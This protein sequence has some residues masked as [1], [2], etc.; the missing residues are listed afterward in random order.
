MKI[1]SSLGDPFAAVVVAL[2]VVA[3]LLLPSG[4]AQFL[5]GAPVPPLFATA[6]ARARDPALWLGVSALFVYGA[7]LMVPL[8][9]RALLKARRPVEP[10]R[11]MLLTLGSFLVVGAL[12]V[13]AV[14]VSPTAP[15]PRFGFVLTSRLGLALFLLSLSALYYPLVYGLLGLIGAFSRRVP[16]AP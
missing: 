14:R 15:F 9:V 10:Q 8:S 3:P 11:V 1:R 7:T 5:A 2:A 13:L 16:A 6:A 4:L 12:G